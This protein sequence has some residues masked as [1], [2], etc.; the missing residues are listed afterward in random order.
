MRF[1]LLGFT[2]GVCIAQLIGQDHAVSAV[3]RV[4][5]RIDTCHSRTGPVVLLFLGPP[6][7]GKTMLA[8]QV[9]AWRHGNLPNL[10]ASSKY[11]FFS[12][13]SM[14]SE[15]DLYSFLSP[16]LGIVG[17]GSLSRIF[18]KESSPVI[19]LDEIEK[20][21][22]VFVGD[23]LLSLTDDSG[24]SIQDKK[25]HFR[26]NTNS[27]IFILTSNCFT[28]HLTDSNITHGLSINW[29]N[30]ASNNPSCQT[31]KRPDIYRRLIAGHVLTGLH[32]PYILFT[33]PSREDAVKLVDRAIDQTRIYW[34]KAARQSLV[35]KT[36]ETF[37]AVNL[38]D[39]LFRSPTHVKFTGGYSVLQ[40]FV[41]GQINGIADSQLPHPIKITLSESG[42]LAQKQLEYSLTYAMSYI[43]MFSVAFAILLL[44][45][46]YPLIIVGIAMNPSFLAVAG[47]SVAT[48]SVLWYWEY[49]WI[50]LKCLFA[51]AI[52]YV[53]LAVR[54]ETRVQM[55]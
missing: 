4:L 11:A 13:A 28:E 54:K 48:V 5:S 22:P 16:P 21:H 50:V 32:L 10:E 33:P 15:H 2:W 29:F 27:A 9:A 38:F 37:Y 34:D 43:W 24:G 45:Y 55:G 40:S 53:Y 36:L 39:K 41:T 42:E 1:W 8:R 35:N 26:Y 23:M 25:S 30:E 46:F 7:C 18:Q 52:V 20:A 14:K 6:G 3:K 47:V 31:L 44:V 17:E 19:V 51:G 49:L 12:M